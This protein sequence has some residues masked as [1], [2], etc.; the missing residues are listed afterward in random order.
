MVYLISL[1]LIFLPSYLIRFSVFGIPTTVLEILIYIVFIIG[2]WQ[3]RKIGFR[4]I[5]LK[6]VLPVALLVIAIVLSIIITPDKNVALGE[7]KGFFFDPML[8]F[9]L[10][11]QFV[12]NQDT[13]KLFIGLSISGLFVAGYTILQK[14][15]GN[16][17][18]DGRVIGVFGY[19]PNYTALFLVPISV[20]LAA[21]GIQLT[22]KKKLGP[23]AVSC[24]LFAINLLAIYYSGSRGGFLAVGAGLGIFALLYFWSQIKKSLTTK[25]IIVILIIMASYI[26][27]DLFR[28][29]FS[30]SLDSGRVVTSNNLRAQI[31][32]TTLELGAK[33][34]IL[35]VGLGNFQNAFA[36]LTLNRG[37]FPEYITP[38]ALT[39]HNIF[40]MFWLSTGILGLIAFIWLLVAFFKEGL[41]KN[42]NQYKYILMAV[43]V[44]ILAYGLIE[45]S[46]WK[47]DLG[48]IFW[49]IFALVFTL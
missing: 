1:I 9:W 2:L 49:T 43:M 25:I 6:I 8:V 41:S 48:I 19:S 7:A 46:I 26:A 32:Q 36:E 27:W 39:P 18:P 4:K 13:K 30:A 14:I 47:N 40:L 37:N 24:V 10:I 15:L 17:T 22:A 44:S 34:P 33:H 11:Y 21:Y 20:W 12:K 5:P 16:L 35:G 31:W 45:S 28:P 23:L 42:D 38:M 29:D 3:A